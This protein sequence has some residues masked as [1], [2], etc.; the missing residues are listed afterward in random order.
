MKES[1]FNIIAAYV[2]GA[3]VLDLFAGTG[4]LG[5]EALS[6]G[7]ESAVFVDKSQE[8]AGIIKDNLV[9]TK[10]E[11]K[12]KVFVTEAAAAVA[13]LKADGC[14]FDLIFL[15]PPY[16]RGLVQESLNIIINN[17][18]MSSDCLIVAESDKD[19]KMPEEAGPFKLI[20]SQKYGDTVITL[21]KEKL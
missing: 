17:G 10:L 16:N 21:Y 11:D 2:H 19:D 5:I 14:A 18:I 3:K 12:A 9:H 15:D 6:R 7:A 13:R 8:C 4:N 20:R 1:L